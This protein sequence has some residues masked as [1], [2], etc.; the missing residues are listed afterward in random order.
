MKRNFVRFALGISLALV[1]ATGVLVWAF[2][3]PM[4]PSLY[5]PALKRDLTQEQRW[6]LDFELANEASMKEH[7]SRRFEAPGSFEKRALWFEATAQW[8]PIADLMQQM[9]D[10][11]KSTMRNNEKAFNKLVEM[12]KQG[13]VGATCMAWMFYKHFKKEDTAKWHYSYDDAARAALK[14]KDS[15]HPVC[16]GV[17]GALYLDGDLGYP[18]N[19]F[20]GRSYLLRRA[21]AGFYGNQ[22]QSLPIATASFN[23]A[24]HQFNDPV[25][26][27]IAGALSAVSGVA[28]LV[29]ALEKGDL[30]RTLKDGGSVDEVLHA[31][32]LCGFAINSIAGCTQLHCARK[33]FALNCAN[34]KHWALQA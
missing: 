17:E 13:D 28:S 31:Q 24:S 11:R 22:K 2:H 32:Y 9:I 6:K 3:P 12:G 23:F 33:R 5:R 8:Y 26:A 14:L 7:N 1:S 21:V 15:G 10:F 19:R 34:G 27:E 16:C 18:Q 4:P 29:K 30:G 25:L 20:L